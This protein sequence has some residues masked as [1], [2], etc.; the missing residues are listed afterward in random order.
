M[1]CPAPSAPPRR[2]SV[3]E[4]KTWIEEQAPEQ[5]AISRCRHL[6]KTHNDCLV[7][8]AGQPKNEGLNNET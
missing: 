4:M 5:R 1:R 8:A 2:K 3:D 7:T 6:R